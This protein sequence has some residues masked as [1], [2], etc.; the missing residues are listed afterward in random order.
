M[1]TKD[2]GQKNNA[3]PGKKREA[4][5]KANSSL[6]SEHSEH[7]SPPGQRH[8]SG[9]VS[10]KSKQL[11]G[12]SECQQNQTIHL[13]SSSPYTYQPSNMSFF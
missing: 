9:G 10:E 2:K 4:K 5:R 3:R 7:N 8:G 12:I 1:S 13:Y 11:E 6:N